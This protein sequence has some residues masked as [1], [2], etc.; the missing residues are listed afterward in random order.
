M[1]AMR[2]AGELGAEMFQQPFGMVA[3]GFRLDHGGFARRGQASKQYRRLELSRGDRRLVDDGDRVACALQRERQPAA[4]G[5][6]DHARA[7]PLQR[8]EHAPHRPLAQGGIAD[9][10]RGYRIASDRADRKTHPGAGIAEIERAGRL[11]EAPDADAM[12]APHALARALQPG[13]E[14][15]HGLGGVQHVLA[16][17]EAINRALADRQRPE[18]QGTVRDRFVPRHPGPALQRATAAGGQRCQIGRVHR[19]Y[20]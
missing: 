12:D 1:L 2:L 5:G 6:L 3:G 19:R 9:E 8:I 15:A 11:G 13:A 20:P 10:G 7:H 16:F 4:L 17:Q 14:R 18:N